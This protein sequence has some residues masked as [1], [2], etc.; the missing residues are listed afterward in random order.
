NVASRVQSAAEP[1]SVV[2]TAAVHELVSGLFVVEDRGAHQLKGVEQP[3]RLYR[4]IQPTVARRRTHRPA[5][6]VQTPFVGRDEDMRLLLSRWERVR[7]GQGQLVLVT[8]EPGIGKSRLVEEFR[9]R[10]RD[11]PHVWVECAGEQLFQSTPFHAVTRILDQ[12]L[13]WRGDESPEDRVILLESRLERAGLKLAEAVPLI[14]EMLSLPMPDKYPA[15]MFAPE[16]KLKRL[17]ANL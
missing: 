9:S 16:Q 14:A 3:V 12:G 5:A 8:G 13:G 11:D 7:E 4:P 2:I 17:V 1:D 10:I 6:S 15:L